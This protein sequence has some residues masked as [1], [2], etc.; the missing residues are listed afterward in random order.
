MADAG[1]KTESPTERR[2]AEARR[3]GQVAKSQDLATAV[4]SLAALLAVAALGAGTLDKSALIMRDMFAGWR[5]AD[6]PVLVASAVGDIRRAFQAAVDM[7]WPYMLVAV[8][9][10]AVL[11]YVQVG[12]LIATDPLKPKLD[13]LDPLKGVGRVYGRRGLVR[14]LAGI[15][16]LAAAA[17]VAWVVVRARMD[18]LVLLPALDAVTGMTMIARTAF[19]VAALLSVI[20]ILI[21]L[22]DYIF[23]RW[24]HNQDLRMTKSEVKDER[25]DME[26]DINVKRRRMRLYQDMVRNRSG[27]AAAQ[28]DVIVTN[29]THYSVALKYEPG[30]MRAPKVTGKGADLM[31]LRMREI[32]R[33]AGVPI[34]ERPPLARALFAAVPVGAEI[35]PEHYEA[36]AE[37]LA[38]VYRVDARRRDAVNAAANANADAD[39]ARADAPGR[40]RGD[41]A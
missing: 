24:Q 9:V 11:H 37:V 36:V 30:D 39:P 8:A 3:K 28:A 4:G 13:R 23:Q 25:R 14:S 1:E 19:E 31:A 41:A 5:S 38:F 20:L 10:G 6:A 21:G 18:R 35:R 40:S 15:L 2:L 29:P 16:K 17:A 34:V 22:G 27:Q 26:G 7:T 33:G 12:P 32:A